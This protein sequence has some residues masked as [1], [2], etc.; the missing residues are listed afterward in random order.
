LK[1]GREEGMAGQGAEES[2]AS[3]FVFGS[4]VLKLAKVESKKKI[5]A[6]IF[7]IVLLGIIGFNLMEPALAFSL[8][9]PLAMFFI[10]IGYLTVAYRI[11]RDPSGALLAALAPGSGK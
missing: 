3:I 5:E 4:F 1:D 8:L 10:G 11:W 6:L 9:F 7:S 2:I